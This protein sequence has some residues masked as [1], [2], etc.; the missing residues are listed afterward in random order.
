MKE[1]RD[2]AERR[3]HKRACVQTIVV[4]ILNS[5]EP[6]MIGSITDI[7]LGGVKFTYNEQTEAPASYQSIDLIADDCYMEDIPCKNTWEGKIETYS[8][9][10]LTDLKQCGIQFEN[11]IPSQIFLLRNFINRCASLGINSIPSNDPA[12]SFSVKY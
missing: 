4:G 9:S 11:L 2:F 1:S 8:F 10:K 5:D 3:Q 12:F 7:S 6:V